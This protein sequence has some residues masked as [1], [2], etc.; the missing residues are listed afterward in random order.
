VKPRPL[1]RAPL[2]LLLALAACGETRAAPLEPAPRPR[3]DVAPPALAEPKDA[4]TPSDDRDDM[5]VFEGFAIDR[6]EA[7]LVARRPS[8]ERARHP[9]TQRPEPGV[10]YEARSEAGVFP[11]AYIDR[12]EAQ[13]ACA[14][15]GKRLCTRAEWQRACFGSRRTTYPYGDRLDPGR[16]NMGKAHLLTLVFGP[17][18]RRWRYDDFNDPRLDLFASFLAK[19]GDYEGCAGEGGV[20]DLVGNLHEWVSDTAD[21]ALMARLAAE[22]VSRN[23]QPW[24]SGNAVFMGGFFSTREEHGAGCHFTTVAH[25]ARYHDYSIGFRC[26]AAPADRPPSAY[27]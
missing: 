5:A 18:P 3:A 8:G 21:A 23:W 7:H 26:C 24:A 19:T 2:A 22:G 14:N 25:E 20:V 6:H 15:A 27:P 9:H 1:P 13:A 10:I 4:G 17:D 16:C 12:A 11:Q